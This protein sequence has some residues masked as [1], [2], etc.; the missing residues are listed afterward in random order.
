MTHAFFKALLFMGAGSVIGAMG[1]NQDIDRMG[2][3]RYALP[4]THVMFAVGAL[5]LAAF[6][7]TAGFFSKDEILA[8]AL[9]RGGLYTGLALVG[10]VAAFLT[11]FYSFRM[12]FRVFW[13]DPVPEA[14]ALEIGEVP[15]AE[16]RNPATGEEE[17][18][19]VGFPGP[20][21]HF[22]ERSATMR[23]AMVPLALGAAFS[24]VV[25]IPHVTDLLERFLEPTF[26]G[27][28]FAAQAPGAGAEYAGLAVGAVVALLGIYLAHRLYL[29]RPGTTLR[30]RERHAGVHRFLERKWYFDELYE[31][32][33]VR[34]WAASGRFGR[35]VVE[36]G[37]VQGVMVG[38]T[39]DIVR[40]SSYLA[41]AVQSGYL[42]AYAGLLLA[43]LSVLALYFLIAAS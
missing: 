35:N 11:A 8:F 6:P 20:E 36:S 21:H 34:P 42:R 2:G 12:V 38:G 10:Y 1:G 16:H 3:F 19:D 7:L 37:F 4:F 17:D 14:R 41:R 33:V 15:H 18:T 30:L 32:A 5:A 25:G 31:L 43:G 23:T 9:N 22:A 40:A 28:R 29:Q 39:S 27:S 24:G 26:E 13:G